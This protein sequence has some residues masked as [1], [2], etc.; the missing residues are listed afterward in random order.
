MPVVSTTESTSRSPSC[1]ASAQVPDGGLLGLSGGSDRQGGEGLEELPEQ[2]GGSGPRLD[3]RLRRVV[4]QPR[5][6]RRVSELMLGRHLETGELTALRQPGRDRVEDPDLGEQVAI[7]DRRGL[8]RLVGLT[9]VGRIEPSSCARCRLGGRAWMAGRPEAQISRASSATPQAV[10]PVIF[11]VPSSSSARVTVGSVPP[12]HPPRVCGV[13][14]T[15]GCGQHSAKASRRR[16]RADA[17]YGR[18]R[19]PRNE[20]GPDRRL[21]SSGP[22]RL[23]QHRARPKGFEPLTF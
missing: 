8:G 3:Q 9:C 14:P 20:S 10:L 23:S 19:G 4:E 7:G 12:R 5:G 15:T 6:Q 13:L 16:R 11:A 1:A 17:A 21:R 18:H 2:L 22:V